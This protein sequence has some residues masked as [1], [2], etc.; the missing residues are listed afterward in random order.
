M[1]QVPPSTTPEESASPVVPVCYR[2]PKRETYLRCVRCDRPICPECLREAPVGFQCPECVA[3]GRRTVRQTRTVFGGSS[4]GVLGYVTKALIFINVVMLVVSASTGGVGGLF[5]GGLGGL[6]GGTTPLTNWGSV[7][8]VAQFEVRGRVVSQAPA[9]IATGEYYRL[10][11][12]MFLHYGLLH[13]ALNMWALWVLGRE[14]EAR[15]GPARFL[16]L[17]LVAGLGGSVACY[18]FT[19]AVQAAG[20]S[21]ALYGLF[22]ALFVVF[23]KLN[24]STSSIITVL[25]INLVFSITVPGIS[26]AAHIGGLIV[27]TLVGVALTYP[28]REIRNR[29]AIA[30]V[31]GLLLFLGAATVAQTVHINAVY[32]ALGR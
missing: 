13:L 22:G 32:G 18:I 24:L 19:P 2:H 28:P 11:T 10:F 6:L 3:Q 29:V 20:A 16:S 27:G 12:S 15:L 25:V 26:I 23:R 1:S 8:G 7:W 30:T 17:Y 21:G 31:V 14:L 9:G 5:G 4:R